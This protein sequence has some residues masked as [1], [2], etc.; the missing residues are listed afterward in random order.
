MAHPMHRRE[1]RSRSTARWGQPDGRG[2]TYVISPSHTRSPPSSWPPRQTPGRP[3]SAQSAPRGWS[4][5]RAH[6]PARPTCHQV[7]FLYHPGHPLP[8]HPD[9]RR[10]GGR[11]GRAARPYVSW[12]RRNTSM[13]CNANSSSASRPLDPLAVSAGRNTPTARQL[14]HETH[15]R[16]HRILANECAEK[17]YLTAT[18]SRPKYTRYLFLRIH[19]PSATRRFRAGG[20]LPGSYGPASPPRQPPSPV[21]A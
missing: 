8:A 19:A 16:S 3:R 9:P 21:P 20:A 5:R 18:P 12:L 11:R 17:A 15:R 13:M 7:V 4:P 6:A 10:T 2:D 14:Q 1:A